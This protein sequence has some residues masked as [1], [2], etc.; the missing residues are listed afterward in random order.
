MWQS[1]LGLAKEEAVALGSRLTLSEAALAQTNEVLQRTQVH[2]TQF[3]N[4]FGV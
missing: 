4:L 3:Q 1:E 2:L